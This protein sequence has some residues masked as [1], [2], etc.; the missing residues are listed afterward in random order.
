MYFTQ[1]YIFAIL[2]FI[3]SIILWYLLR[4]KIKTYD[5]KTFVEKTTIFNIIGIVVIS[6]SPIVGVLLAIEMYLLIKVDIANKTTNNSL[7]SRCIR[8]LNKEF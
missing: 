6:I 8:F 3:L 5:N 4:Y 2:H 7:F 1:F